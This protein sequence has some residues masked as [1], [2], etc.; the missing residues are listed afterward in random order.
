MSR[1]LSYAEPGKGGSGTAVA[2]GKLDVLGNRI[3]QLKVLF[4]QLPKTSGGRHYGSRLVFARDGKLF[5]TIGERGESEWAQDFTINRGQVIRINSDGS[6]PEQNP[7]V[8][9]KGYRPEVWTYGHRNPQGAT[10]H[11]ETGELWTVEHGARGGS[12]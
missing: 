1:N 6:I 2:R 8:G 5:I 11:P 7:F 4:Q 3:S 10:L 12:G 9:R